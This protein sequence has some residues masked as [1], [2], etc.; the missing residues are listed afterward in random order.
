MAATEVPSVPQ[1]AHP[2]YGDA[3]LS[4]ARTAPRAAIRPGD[5]GQCRGGREEAA[6]PLSGSLYANDLFG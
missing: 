1:L 2:P 6:E 4:A 5:L 3:Q